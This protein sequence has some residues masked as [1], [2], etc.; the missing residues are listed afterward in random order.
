MFIIDQKNRKIK[1]TRGDTA[2]MLVQIFDIEGKEYEIKD[3]DVITFT[4]RKNSASE[5]SL[6]KVAIPSHHIIFESN[7]TSQLTPGLYKYDLQLT[8][9]EGGVYTIIQDNYF[10]LL[11]EITR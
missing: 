3:S 1:L 11:P 9:V 4:L 6:T 5:V 8:T 7:D 2:T 10:E